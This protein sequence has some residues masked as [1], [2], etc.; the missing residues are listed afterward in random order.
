[1]AGQGILIIIIP[2]D[3]NVEQQKSLDLTEVKHFYGEFFVEK[4]VFR[5]VL[6]PLTYRA[7]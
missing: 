2:N 6:I 1:M 5:L 7:N 3:L 4:D